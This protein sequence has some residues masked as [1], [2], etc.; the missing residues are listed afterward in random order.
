M[1]KMRDTALIMQIPKIDYKAIIDINYNIEY[2]YFNQSAEIKID[3]QA[4]FIHKALKSLDIWF[5]S[6]ISD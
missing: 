5:E 4:M 6:N 3:V 1:L 2:D